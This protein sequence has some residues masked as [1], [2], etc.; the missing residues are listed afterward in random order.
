M[1][2]EDQFTHTREY[3][4]KILSYMLAD[5]DFQEIATSALAAENFSDRAMQWFFDTMRS[6]DYCLSKVTIQEELVKASKIKVIHEDEI[7][8]YLEYYS[9][10]SMPPAPVEEKHIQDTLGKFI[11]AQ[12]TKTALVEAWKLQKEG[13]YDEIADMMQ[14]ATNK[15]LHMLDM[16]YDYMAKLEERTANRENAEYESR[17]PTGIPDLDDVLYGGLRAKQLGLIVGGTGRGKSIFLEWLGKSA[18]ILNKKVLYITLEL[19]KEEIAERYDALLA[20]I[21]INELKVYNE[22]VFKAIAPLTSRYK[23]GL[24]IQEYPALGATPDTIRAYLR[25]LASQG[26]IPDVIL[27]DYLDLVKSPRAYSSSHDEL[28]AITKS[29]HGLSKEFNC[30]IWTATQ[31]NRGGL[32]METP[33]ETSVA[34]AV[35]KLFTADVAMFLACTAEERAAREMRI[36]VAKNRNGPAP[37]TIRIDTDYARMTFYQPGPASPLTAPESYVKPDDLKA[38]VEDELTTSEIGLTEDGE[39]LVLE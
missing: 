24:M 37:R 3:Q 34:G 11:R 32:A 28:D 5:P 7:D 27:I 38:K 16:G 12:A 6:S 33:D 20:Q 23:G 8:K 10:I 17:Y 4:L 30:A 39:L 22:D 14:E 18:L 2:E 35:A 29:L 1:S 21:K 15:A 9:L 25:R 26:F 31:L 13:R 19:S 36:V